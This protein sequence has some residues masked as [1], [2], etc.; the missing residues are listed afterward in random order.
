MNCWMSGVVRVVEVGGVVDSL[1]RDF[2]EE[3]PQS[4]TSL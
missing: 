1:V 4:I 3:C 2:V